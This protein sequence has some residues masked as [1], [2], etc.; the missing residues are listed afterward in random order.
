MVSIQLPEE[1]FA[2]ATHQ[3]RYFAVELLGSLPYYRFQSAAFA[4]FA[5]LTSRIA[6]HPYLFMPDG[7]LGRYLFGIQPPQQQESS[8]RPFLMGYNKKLRSAA[9]AM[10]AYRRAEF[11]ALGLWATWS[12]MQWRAGAVD[13]G[14]N[15][16][17]WV[18]FERVVSSGRGFSYN[19]KLWV[20]KGHYP[21]M[22][23][24]FCLDFHKNFGDI[25]ITARCHGDQLM[26]DYCQ[27]DIGTNIVASGTV[28]SANVD[29]DVRALARHGHVGDGA[30]D[31]AA[32]EALLNYEGNL[33]L[34]SR[35]QWPPSLL[36]EVLLKLNG[37]LQSATAVRDGLINWRMMVVAMH[38]AMDFMVLVSVITI[39]AVVLNANGRKGYAKDRCDLLG[40][41]VENFRNAIQ[42]IATATCGFT[43]NHQRL[44]AAVCQWA[45]YGMGKSAALTLLEND[46]SIPFRIVV[47]EM[48]FGLVGSDLYELTVGKRNWWNWYMQHHIEQCVMRAY[49][50]KTS[51]ERLWEWHCDLSLQPHQFSGPSRVYM[52]ASPCL[53]NED[54]LRLSGTHVLD[55]NFLV[56]G[57]EMPSGL[58]LR[59]DGTLHRVL[60]GPIQDGCVIGMSLLG[61]VTILTQ[62][63]MLYMDSV[64]CYRNSNFVKPQQRQLLPL[65]SEFNNHRT[66]ITINN[67]MFHGGFYCEGPG[68]PT[69]RHV[70]PS[71]ALNNPRQMHTQIAYI[72]DS[73]NV[74]TWACRLSNIFYRFVMRCRYRHS[75]WI[76]MNAWLL[77]RYFGSADPLWV[78]ELCYQWVCQYVPADLQCRFE[79]YLKRCNRFY[80]QRYRNSDNLMQQ[81]FKEDVVSR[82]L[83]IQRQQQPTS[84]DAYAF[85]H[86]HT[87]SQHHNHHHQRHQVSPESPSM[88]P[89][90][91]LLRRFEQHL[92]DGGD[93]PQ[94][95]AA[96]ENG[97]PARDA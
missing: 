40:D 29:R 60:E 72:L 7:P 21:A 45:V 36:I 56:L 69:L 64:G 77:R 51:R 23:E 9:T 81:F 90:Y 31:T 50:S 41:K 35:P 58:D 22:F 84:S 63:Q 1:D 53:V 92:R 71:A 46:V 91:R 85:Q 49:Y 15:Y 44:F 70:S 67:G 73:S 24:R 83:E 2:W 32:D 10:Q 5:I 52:W 6:S 37:A 74:L 75:T 34:L 55:C 4:E 26:P 79:L 47:P 68:L 18:T 8:K 61:F 3:S 43:L 42:L 28:Q 94:T 17:S 30:S 27:Y 93:P 20:S 76:D 38:A 87:R 82:F 95:A 14:E 13:N 12:L 86:G 65:G 25:D 66:V 78:D 11:F 62:T 39:N 88:H 97:Q 54:T 89:R 57:V 80:F 19:E 16:R 33:V 48:M 96:A 59:S